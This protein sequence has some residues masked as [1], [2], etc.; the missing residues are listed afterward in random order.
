[1]GTPSLGV[2]EVAKHNG[3]THPNTEAVPALGLPDLSP[4]VPGAR[5]PGRGVSSRQLLCEGCEAW[6]LAVAELLPELAL[7]K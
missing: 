5:S 1:M 6:G 4:D 7:H 3:Q 2:W